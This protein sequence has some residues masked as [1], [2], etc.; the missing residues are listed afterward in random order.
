L[1]QVLVA[2]GATQFVADPG[3]FFDIVAKLTT[4]ITT[5]GT[6]QCEVQYVM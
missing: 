2:L 5:N 3:G 1:W 6:V 4:G